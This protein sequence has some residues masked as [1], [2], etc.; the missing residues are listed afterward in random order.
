M[1]S[2]PGPIAAAAVE[3]ARRGWHVIPLHGIDPD[4]GGCTCRQGSACP[5][6]GKH[7]RSSEWQKNA[8]D[9]PE[10]VAGWWSHYGETANVGIVAGPSGLAIVDIDGPQGM[11]VFRQLTG[12]EATTPLIVRTGR[13]WHLYFAATDKATRPYAGT[14]DM[15]GL[16]LRA[17]ASYVVA[18]PSLHASGE[19][20]TWH[21]PT[22]DDDR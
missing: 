6:P 1:N 14:G 16:D 17:G 8:S 9:N 10:L 18:P 5:S 15:K 4:A 7:P 20:Y 3:Y 2:T 21:T 12:G 11:E 19:R 22:R 13:G